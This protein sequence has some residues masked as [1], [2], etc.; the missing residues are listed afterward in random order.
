MITKQVFSAGSL[1]FDDAMGCPVLTSYMQPLHGRGGLES[2]GGA[3]QLPG[4]HAKTHPAFRVTGSRGG[5]R[6]SIARKA[7]RPLSCALGVIACFD[8]AVSTPQT[9]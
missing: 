1:S 4:T 7:A 2:M 6:L 5:I 8:D 3:A 9:A